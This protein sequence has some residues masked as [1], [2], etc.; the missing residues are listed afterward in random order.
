[1]EAPGSSVATYRSIR[2]FTGPVSVK[3]FASRGAI[4]RLD[5]EADFGAGT[6]HAWF[7]DRYEWHPV[8][9]GLYT[10][11]DDDDVRPTNAVHAA[12]VELKAN[13]G[14][15][16]YWMKGEATVALSELLS[17][18]PRPPWQGV[19]GLGLDIDD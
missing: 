3:T 5:Y 7:Q 10:R 1:V 8:Y 6:F 18:T 19:P 2:E 17:V 9:S 11:F 14:A 15:A 16:D 4:D 13:D 12:C